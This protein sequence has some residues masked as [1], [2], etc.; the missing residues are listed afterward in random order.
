MSIG[1]LES[2]LLRQAVR[3]D[4]ASLSQ[5]LL[6]HYDGLGRHIA[7]RISAELEPLV[8]AD[9][10]LHQT[11]VRAAQGIGRYEP[12][13][14]GAFRA[15]LTTIADNLIRDA[16]KRNRRERR[17]GPE[18]G[19]GGAAGQTGSWAALVE[20]I[21]G[22]GTS[23]SVGTQRR[24]NARRVRAALAAL[25]AEYR[26]VIERHYLMEQ[27]LDEIAGTKGTTKGAIRALCYRARKRLRELMG[28]SSLYFSG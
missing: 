25:P 27:S 26:D 2:D 14:E 20:R 17:A 9:D 1:H 18:Q 19:K 5:V 22:D 12:R 28:Q 7:R 24:E 23:P 6:L 21:A 11:L 16:R 10:I 3:G 13:Q 15:W 8:V 4:R